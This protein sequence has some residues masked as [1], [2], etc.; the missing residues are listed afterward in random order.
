MTPAR[1]LAIL[2]ELPLPARHLLDMER[3]L[4]IWKE[5]MGIRVTQIVSSRGCPFSC[6]FCDKRVFGSIVRYNSPQRVVEEMRLLYE[7]YNVENI[8]FEEDLFTFNKKRVLDLC[9]TIKSQLTEKNWS[10]QA[11]V[12]TVDL[13]MLQQMKDA[14]CTDLMFGVES[15]SERIREF[16]KKGS[17]IAQT[18]QAF[19]WAT[20]VGINA[21]MFLMVGVPGEKQSDIECTKKLIEDLKP[22][23]INISFLTPIP[24]TDIFE[25]TKYLIKPGVDFCNFNEQYE[26]VYQPEAFEVQPKDRLHELMYFF[27]DKFGSEIDPRSSIGDGTSF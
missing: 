21:G 11:R 12:D 15:G 3:Y 10:A 19:K 1:A 23:T 16:L 9:N 6:A 2:D 25:R 18:K 20:Q 26:S 7:T 17:S 13:S 22:K 8:Y 24:G 4:S 27:L 14:G 5:H